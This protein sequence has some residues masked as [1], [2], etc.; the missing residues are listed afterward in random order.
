MDRQMISIQGNSLG[1]RFDVDLDLYGP[2]EAKSTTKLKIK[3]LDVV[4]DSL[5]TEVVNERTLPWRIERTYQVRCFDLRQPW[6]EEI[7]VQP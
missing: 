5:D 4:I 3:E 1:R 2:L 7:C 6:W